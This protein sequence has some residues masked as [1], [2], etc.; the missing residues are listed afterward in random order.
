M[1]EVKKDPA[2][3]SVYPTPAQL[4]SAPPGYELLEEIGCGGILLGHVALGHEVSVLTLTGGQVGGTPAE[5]TREMDRAAELMS[6]RLFHGNVAESSVAE[7]G[8]TITEIERVIEEVQP[9]TVYTH[10]D[11][12]FNQDHRSVY[13]ATMAATRSSHPSVSGMRR[14]QPRSISWS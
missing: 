6:A 8:A 1:G 3:S 2:S 11:H 14:F 9:D 10:S 7:G 5:R 13:Q 12:D 4:P